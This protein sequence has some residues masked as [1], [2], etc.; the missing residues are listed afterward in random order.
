M[1]TSVT[2]DFGDGTY[3]FRLG[4]DQIREL[5]KTLDMGLLRIFRRV[6][7]DDCRLEDCEHTIRL[8]LIG[9]GMEP[10]KALRL[11]R[12]YVVPPLMPL[13]EPVGK[14]LM[15]AIVSPEPDLGKSPAGATTKETAANPNG[16]SPPLSTH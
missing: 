10:V 5:E 16:S 3:I 7:S 11:Q 14:I 15:P 9:G 1:D 12:K 4:V 13:R 2:L 6:N 8:G